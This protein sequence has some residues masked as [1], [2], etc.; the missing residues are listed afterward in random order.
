[1]IEWVKKS[2][3][4]FTKRVCPLITND[5]L[6]YLWLTSKDQARRSNVYSFISGS[7]HFTTRVGV[8]ALVGVPTLVLRL[9]D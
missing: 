4:P 8:R 1:M 6:V 2:G 7:L 9:T 5:T 3:S